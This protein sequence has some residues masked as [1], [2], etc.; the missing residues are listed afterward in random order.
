MDATDQPI[1]QRFVQR[2]VDDLR[3]PKA[4]IFF[5]DLI[6]SAG[7]GWLLFANALGPWNG[8]FR[9]MSFVVAALLLYR[10]LAF[11]HELFHQQSM[12]KFRFVWHVLAGVPLLIPFLLYLPIH[13]NHH[14]SKAYGTKEDGEY[15]HFKGRARLAIAKLFALN[16]ALPLALWVRFALLT[17]LAVLHSPIR[18]QM[19]PEFVHLALRLPFRA[20]DIKESSR[21]EAFAIEW[22]CAVFSWGLVC[23]CVLGYGEV[24]LLWAALVILIATLNTIRTL[25]ATHLYVEGAEGRNAREQM[26]DSTNLDSRSPLALLLCPVGLRFHALH[27][28]APYLPYHALPE[29]HHRLMQALPQGSEYHQLTVPSFSQGLQRLW[30]ATSERS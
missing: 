30:R 11:I 2:L 27:H 16:L 1:N 19:I 7:L 26:L 20:A 17:P 23:L 21:A 28:I 13:Q 12:A 24:V 15:E 14:S 22:M 10:A 29:A 8:F 18:T 25:G 4:S 3:T 9:G 6:A 5:G